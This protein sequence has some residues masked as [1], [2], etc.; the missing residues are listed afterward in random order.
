MSSLTLLLFSSLVRLNQPLIPGPSFPHHKAVVRYTTA[1]PSG[2]VGAALRSGRPAHRPGRLL[3]AASHG[4]SPPS[5]LKPTHTRFSSQVVPS[6]L[7]EPLWL[8]PRCYVS[9]TLPAVSRR[10][11]PEEPY[12][13][14]VTSTENGWWLRSAPSSC[15]AAPS[16]PPACHAPA[17]LMFGVGVLSTWS[18]GCEAVDVLFPI[19]CLVWAC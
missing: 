1:C 2:R 9:Y 6:T 3:A 12:L 4:Q 5:S 18:V 16:C 11:L 15:A 7:T 10:F 17:C 14:S 13:M 8:L 19:P